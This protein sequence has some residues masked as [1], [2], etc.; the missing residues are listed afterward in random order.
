MSEELSPEEEMNR[1]TCWCG[2]IAC[3]R[4]QGDELRNRIVEVIA[5]W[6]L[7][8]VPP[9]VIAQAIINEFELT[10][11]EDLLGEE[12]GVDHFITL[13][14]VV[15]KWLPRHPEQAEPCSECG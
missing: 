6:I 7:P 4:H 11:E 3:R 13:D 8:G 5:D 10:V 15:G 2:R 12:Y 14:R 1:L 9:E